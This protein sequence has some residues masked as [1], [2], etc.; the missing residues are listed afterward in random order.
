MSF[1]ALSTTC[2]AELLPFAILAA[3]G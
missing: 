2:C 3:R 1:L